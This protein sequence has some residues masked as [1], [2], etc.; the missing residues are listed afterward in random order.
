MRAIGAF[1]LG[2]L[3]VAACTG[4]APDA[5]T[6]QRDSA[7]VTIVE[8]SAPRWQ[9]TDAW[10][11]DTTPLLDLART[12]TGPNHEF[13]Q[14]VDAL[15]LADGSIV[16]ADGGSHQVRRFSP[17]GDFQ[18]ALGREGDG[19]GEFRGFENLARFRGD[20]ILAF[21]YRLGRATILDAAGQLGR[22]FYP[23]RQGP[24]LE[25]L[26]VLDDSTLVAQLSDYEQMGGNAGL[27][28]IPA[29][30]L[31]ISS[32]GTIL[33]TLTTIPGIETFLLPR[34]DTRPLFP[35]DGHLAAANG[36]AYV[37]SADRM[38]FDVYDAAGRLER[39][40]R[41]P[42]FDLH[43][44][45]DEIQR[46][47][48]FF[49][50]PRLNGNPSPRVRDIVDA[51]PDPAARPAYDQLVVDA[52]GAVWAAGYRAYSDSIGPTRWQVFAPD[53]AWLGTTELPRRLRVFEI[54]EDYV[55]GAYSD[56]LDV[57]HV[58][59]RRLRR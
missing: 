40:V 57:E 21:D 30:V 26:L 5:R 45:P 2:A 12:G 44:S 9:A 58:Q 41:V 28:R 56:S 17:T 52:T 38:E 11:V 54:G 25:E 22:S 42:T 39:I 7:G 32:S 55:L 51:L 16:V 14:V 15:R 35:R 18:W 29:S 34:G 6:V 19:P 37:G 43:L 46:E 24:G 1:V 4:D 47:R 31:M 27:F 10:R 20:S 36:R 48:D 3:T 59:V 33:D 23:V 49:L 8:S 13:Y 53:G 50:G